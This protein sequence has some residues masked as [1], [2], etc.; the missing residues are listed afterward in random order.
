MGKE[1]SVPESALESPYPK[2]EDGKELFNL[3]L[4]VN[5]LHR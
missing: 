5:K 3:S 2:A 1:N 4:K